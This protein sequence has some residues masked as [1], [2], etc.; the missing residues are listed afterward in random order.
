MN[1]AGNSTAGG[2][3]KKIRKR[4]RATK[5]LKLIIG[6]RNGRK[7]EAEGSGNWQRT[8]IMMAAATRAAVTRSPSNELRSAK[9]VAS[10]AATSTISSSLISS[11]RNAETASLRP[12]TWS[13]TF[14]WLIRRPWHVPRQ[15]EEQEPRI[16]PTSHRFSTWPTQLPPPPQQ[17]G[18]RLAAETS[19]T[20][21]STTKSSPTRR[22]STRTKRTILSPPSSAKWKS[23]ANSPAD[24]ATPF[25]QISAPSKVKKIVQIFIF[26]NFRYS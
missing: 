1:P 25:S 26:R 14:K 20:C 11:V 18:R 24:S 15:Q 5:T 19:T 17:P 6:V 2:G 12:P 16:W 7:D 10:V 22:K 23:K 13:I 3:R 4:S 8:R 21:S 9:T